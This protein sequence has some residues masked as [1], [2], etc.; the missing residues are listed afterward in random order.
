MNWIK[1]SELK[2]DN[3]RNV[4]VAIRD[5]GK[6]RVVSGYYQRNH[7]CWHMNDEFFHRSDILDDTTATHWMDF[8]K[9][10]EPEAG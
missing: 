7:G 2:P 10:P 3:N 6:L 1:S 8:P 4:I 9:H 5:D